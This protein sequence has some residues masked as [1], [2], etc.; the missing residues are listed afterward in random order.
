MVF[1]SHFCHIFLL[2]E[3]LWFQQLEEKV[4]QLTKWSDRRPVIKLNN[5]QF[6]EYLRTQPRN[7]SVIMMATA[8]ASSH[9]CGICK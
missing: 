8:L 6:K 7:Y 4:S 3:N 5:D 2:S 9:R 1:I